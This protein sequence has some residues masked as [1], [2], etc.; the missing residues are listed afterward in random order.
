[1]MDELILAIRKTIMAK[2]EKN[3]DVEEIP[4]KKPIAN[5]NQI[6]YSITHIDGTY[7]LVKVGYD[8]VGKATGNLELSACSGFAHAVE[9]YKIETGHLFRPVGA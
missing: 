7:Y 6:A 5:L 8:P 2:K 1:M 4:I 9:R 3:K